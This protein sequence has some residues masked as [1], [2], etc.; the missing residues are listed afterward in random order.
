M[1]KRLKDEILT[2]EN[3]AQMT[4]WRQMR[5]SR[6]QIMREEGAEG[7]GGENE[8]RRGFRMTAF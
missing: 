1:L 6:P 8:I 3:T 7:R 5:S 2:R 4:R